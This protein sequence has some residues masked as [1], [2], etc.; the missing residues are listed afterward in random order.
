MFC[1]MNFMDLPILFEW[2]IHKAETESWDRTKPVAFLVNLNSP[3]A[4]KRKFGG[5]GAWKNKDVFP[6]LDEHEK[7][8][9]ILEVIDIAISSS[10]YPIVMTNEFS[11]SSNT[12]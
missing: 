5:H 9:T 1:E 3:H 6:H 2:Q 8:K 11:K 12:C 7:L 4:S 10:S